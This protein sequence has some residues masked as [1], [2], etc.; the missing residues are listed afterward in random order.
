MHSYRSVANEN[1]SQKAIIIVSTRQSFLHL[2]TTYLG[3][4]HFIKW[5]F[6]MI[7]F[8]SYSTKTTSS[9]QLF[10]HFGNSLEQVFNK[11]IVGDLEDGCVCILVN[12][13]DSL[14]VLH[15]SKMLDGTRDT[16]SNV[17]F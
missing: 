7:F 11:T 2:Y 4:L 5:G 6:Y 16:N 17:Q 9:L 13:D 1:D 3:K 14:G 15:T 10:S 8:Q 12:S